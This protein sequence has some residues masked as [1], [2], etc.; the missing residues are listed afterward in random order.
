[1]AILTGQAI[2]CLRR[3]IA[4]LTPRHTRHAP[5][6][7]YW[8]SSVICPVA[9]MIISFCQAM[10]D[11]W[12]LIILYSDQWLVLLSKPFVFHWLGFPVR[13]KNTNNYR[14]NKWKLEKGSRWIGPDMS[15]QSIVS[16]SHYSPHWSSP[17]DNRREV[18]SVPAEQCW[19]SFHTGISQLC[20]QTKRSN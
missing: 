14:I 17:P 10:C 20:D 3:S 19:S 15:V 5:L 7:K 4:W 9:A 18:C 1:M 6:L 11:S 2:D 12:A 16:L 8:Q 13:A